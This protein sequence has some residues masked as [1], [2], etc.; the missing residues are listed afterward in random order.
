MS[1]CCGVARRV[2]DK[3]GP[4]VTEPQ[5]EGLAEALVA[6]LDRGIFGKQ[7]ITVGCIFD[8]IRERRVSK[9]L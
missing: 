2:I 1:L 9:S 5:A 6:R 7:K 4:G 3:F 8:H